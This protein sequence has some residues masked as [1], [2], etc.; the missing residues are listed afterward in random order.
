MIIDH[1][2]NSCKDHLTALATTSKNNRKPRGCHHQSK[3]AGAGLGMQSLCPSVRSHSSTAQHHHRVKTYLLVMETKPFPKPSDVVSLLDMLISSLV[4]ICGSSNSCPADPHTQTPHPCQD[5]GLT[6][7]HIYKGWI[8]NKW[9]IQHQH[10]AL[11]RVHTC[12]MR[13]CMPGYL[14]FRPVHLSIL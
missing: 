3:C 13:S 2:N 11:M 8:C 10:H 7:S 12:M 4:A 14:T 6:Y 5:K 9:L 1:V